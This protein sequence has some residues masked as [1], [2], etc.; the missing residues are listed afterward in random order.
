MACADGATKWLPVLNALGREVVVQAYDRKVPVVEIVSDTK[1]AT[2]DCS[3]A[4]NKTY[5]GK[6]LLGSTYIYKVS[7]DGN[8]EKSLDMLSLDGKAYTA[9]TDGVQLTADTLY[10]KAKGYTAEQLVAECNVNVEKPS[11]LKAAINKATA[12]ADAVEAL[13]ITGELNNEDLQYLSSLQSL[14]L[15]D[16][17]NATTPQGLAAKRS[18][19]ARL[20]NL[21][22]CPYACRLPAA[23]CSADV[24]LWRTSTLIRR[25]PTAWRL[26]L[27]TDLPT[28]AR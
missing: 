21:S 19:A 16:L 12:D 14:K 3:N 25:R 6:P 18:V 1:N 8:V 24:R 26:T 27:S 2:I 4:Q 11:Q 20:C 15:I 17:E 7:F 5:N 28:L 10:I 9:H 22:R 13:T 23:S